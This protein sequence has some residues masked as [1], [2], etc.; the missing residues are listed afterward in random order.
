MSEITYENYDYMGND[1]NRNESY[2]LF[3]VSEMEGDMFEV[4][5]ISV[6]SVS[7]LML[8][9]VINYTL[10]KMCYKN[11]LF[12]RYKRTLEM[13]KMGE[14]KHQLVKDKKNSEENEKKV[15]A[16]IIFYLGNKI[17]FFLDI[18]ID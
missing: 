7:G 9:F 1:Y 16:Y 14:M 15:I 18:F 12:S 3:N 13:E 10:Y 5:L 2:D 8:I 4:L 6:L 11:G 17:L